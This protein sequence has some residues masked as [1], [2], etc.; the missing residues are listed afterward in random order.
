MPPTP[1][2]APQPPPGWYP[3]PANPA[4]TRYWD[5]TRWTAQTQPPPYQYSYGAPA[6]FAAP[7]QSGYPAAPAI[8]GPGGPQMAAYGPVSDQKLGPTGTPLASFW[9]RL[10]GY[11]IDGLVLAVPTGLLTIPLLRGPIQDFL[12]ELN[13]LDPGVLDPESPAYDPDAFTDIFTSAD[14]WGSLA[15]IALLTLAIQAV[16]WIIAIGK[17]GRTVG[18][19]AV[20]IRAVDAN[21]AIPGYG[22]ATIRFAVPAGASLFGLIPFVGLLGSILQ[23]LIYLWMLWDPMRQGLHDK[24][25]GTFV[26]RY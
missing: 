10:G 1:D 3:D 9:R 19:A 13:T 4:A 26:V 5:G 17:Y 7:P 21:G 14:L 25:A 24:A 8:G 12:D 18:G 2:P 15:W 6:G 23:L 22:R 11:L 16:Y 20:G